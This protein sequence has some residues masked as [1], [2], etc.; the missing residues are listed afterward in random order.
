MTPGQEVSGA[1][2][3]EAETLLAF[4]RLLKVANLLT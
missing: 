2:P 1:K 4:G 3:A